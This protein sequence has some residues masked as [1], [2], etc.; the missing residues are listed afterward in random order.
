MYSNL[1]DSIKLDGFTET[2]EVL[3]QTTSV[4][5]WGDSEVESEESV[6]TEVVVESRNQRLER[7]DEEGDIKSDQVRAWFCSYIDSVK[8]GNI[9]V[10]EDGGQYEIVSVK[11]YNIGSES[12]TETVLET[13]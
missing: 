8:V 10:R 1:L 3:E 13:Y 11:N 6:E 9:V 5:K 7:S 4:N 2:V 12:V